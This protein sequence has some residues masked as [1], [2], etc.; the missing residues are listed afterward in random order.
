MPARAA[1]SFIGE[2]WISRFLSVSGLK[3]RRKE[4]DLTQAE[5]A[6][7]ANCTVF[8]LR[9]IES[10]ERRPSK[11]LAGLLAKSLEIPGEDQTTFIKVARGELNV[12]RLPCAAPVRAAG[13][14]VDSMGSPSPLNLPYQPTRLIGREA[15][16]A[17]LEKLLADPHCRLLT[18]TGLGGIGKTRLAIEVASKQQALFPGGVYY[19]SL[20][21]LNSPEF[22]VPAIARGPGALL[23]GI[24]R[25]ARAA[26]QPPHG[27]LQ[28][29]AP[30][31]TR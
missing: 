17:A 12:E 20:D 11:L 10:G 6:Q 31:G 3:R 18:I 13:H 5:L 25:S 23:Y 27:S 1:I 24:H 30:S 14:P 21:S 22:I 16:L 29:G 2:R 7:R 15:E 4:L 9:K 8:T 26:S 19:V 28:A